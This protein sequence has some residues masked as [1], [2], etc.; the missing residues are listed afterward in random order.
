MLAQVVSSVFMLMEE[1]V[2]VWRDLN[3]SSPV[4]IFGFQFEVGLEPVDVD[5]DRMIHMFYAGMNEL[6]VILEKILDPE[7]LTDLRENI[8]SR[9]FRVSDEQWA[10][11]IYDYAVAWHKNE[12]NRDHIMKTLTPLYL[13][14][15]ASL[16]TELAESNAH[17]VEQRL[18]SL[19]NTF[20]RMKPYLIEKWGRAR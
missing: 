1:Y 7:T 20:Q 13:G 10:R 15:V 11:I 14:K 4:P 2:D 5:T 19:C 3:E 18:E 12:M 8:T 17:E 9:W 6:N 16:V